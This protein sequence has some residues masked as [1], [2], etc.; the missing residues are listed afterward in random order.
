MLTI[1]S[2]TPRNI[3]FA[4]QMVLYWGAINTII[5]ILLLLRGL[6]KGEKFYNSSAW[7]QILEICFNFNFFDDSFGYEN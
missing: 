1:Y 2:L 3:N 6:L 5:I 4:L 7:P